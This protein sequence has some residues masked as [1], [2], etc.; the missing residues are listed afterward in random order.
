MT[1]QL[2]NKSFEEEGKE[3]SLLAFFATMPSIHMCVLSELT[4]LIHFHYFSSTAQ[5][6][7]I[8][9]WHEKFSAAQFPLCHNM[10]WLCLTLRSVYMYVALVVWLDH[11][12]SVQIASGKKRSESLKRKHV[13]LFND[14]NLYI[15]SMQKGP[16]NCL[17]F[18]RK[19]IGAAIR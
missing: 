13:M 15:L 17:F 9:G 18:R 5:I 1:G 7:T 2:L 10:I 14:Y 6:I 11:I 3:K 4:S 8:S 16:K 12:T 19:K